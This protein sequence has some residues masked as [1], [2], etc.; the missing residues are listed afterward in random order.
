MKPGKEQAQ[1]AV[2][3]D[4]GRVLQECVGKFLAAV[5]SGDPNALDAWRRDLDALI[6]ALFVATYALHPMA[7][8]DAHAL[9]KKLRAVVGP[10]MNLGALAQI[11]G[12]EKRTAA[13]NAARAA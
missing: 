13:P 5:D 2:A 7:T 11:V 9:R 8:P 1:R 3:A 4:F 10:A 6:D 12:Q